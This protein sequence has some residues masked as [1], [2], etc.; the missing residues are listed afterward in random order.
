MMFRKI[1][2]V[3]TL[4]AMMMVLF[5]TFVPHHH[6]HA[7][8]CLAHEVCLADDC[9]DDEHTSHS[10]TDPGEEEDHCVSHAK[11]CP[12]DELRLENVPV[13]PVILEAPAPLFSAVFCPQQVRPASLSLHAPPL[14]TWRINC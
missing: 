6:H 14:L 10:D 1:A 12:S 3:P 13:L 9:L 7:M 2:I 5:T 11:Y 4:L 8:I